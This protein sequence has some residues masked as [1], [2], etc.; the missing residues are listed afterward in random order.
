[1]KHWRDLMKTASVR[2]IRQNFPLVMSWIADGEQVVVTMRG[3]RVARLVPEK[4]VRKKRQTLA[5]SA[6]VRRD[7][8]GWPV[9]AGADAAGIV[10]AASGEW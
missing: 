2:D 10:R 7:K 6:A 5:D 1:M 3:R 4:P 9:M 8:S